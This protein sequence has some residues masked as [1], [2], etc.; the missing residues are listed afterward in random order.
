LES[1][2]RPWYKFPLETLNVA[3]TLIAILTFLSSLYPHLTV[4][5]PTPLNS[6]SFFSYRIDVQNDGILPVFSAQC[7]LAVKEITLS[8]GATLRGTGYGTRFVPQECVI[9]TMSPGDGVTFATEKIGPLLG[10][11]GNPDMQRA[12][13]GVVISYIPLFPPI[14]MEYCVHF[15]SY[16]DVGGRQDWFRSPGQCPK[17]P[18]FHF[19]P[20]S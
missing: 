8:S 13:V 7:S 3:A 17:Y 18:W 2:K 12:D 15:V 19:Y 20:Q 14:R 1:A 6:D 16:K 5:A 11:G 10:V 9:G 4:S